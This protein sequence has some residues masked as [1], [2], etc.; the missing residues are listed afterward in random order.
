MAKKSYN[1]LKMWGAYVGAVIGIIQSFISSRIYRDFINIFF[2]NSCSR[3]EQLCEALWIGIKNTIILQ[4]FFYIILGF[5]I[6][7][8][9][10]SLI[11]RIR[12]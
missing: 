8:G 12:K 10:H 11:R 1:P 3:G 4:Y 6:G 2:K 5:L 9:I 7:W